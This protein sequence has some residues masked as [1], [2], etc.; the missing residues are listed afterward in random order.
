MLIF[1][2]VQRHGGGGGG[3]RGNEYTTNETRFECSEKR[4]RV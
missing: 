4:I 2:T 1:A 3:R